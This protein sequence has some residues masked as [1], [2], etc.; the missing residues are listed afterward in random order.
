MSSVSAYVDPVRGTVSVL[1]TQRSMTGPLEG[2][3][4][5]WTAVA[6]AA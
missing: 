4:D 1:L 3:G 2:F 5:F 6:E